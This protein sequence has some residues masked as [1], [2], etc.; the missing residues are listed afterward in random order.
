MKNNRIISSLVLVFAVIFTTTA[1]EYK[2]TASGKV[3]FNGINKISF[4]GHDGNE[5][6]ISTEN[7]SSSKSERA[8]G[9]K[10]IN[11][12]GLDDNTGIGLSVNKE[13]GMTQVDEISKR[14]SK[15]Y[16]VKV[17]NNVVIAYEHSTPHGSK[18]VFSDISSEVEVKTN[19]SSVKLDN[20][21][22]PMTISTVH[23][24]IEA[25][26]SSLNQDD[27]VSIASSHGLVDVS[28]PA[29]SKADVSMKSGWGEMYSDFDIN[30]EKSSSMKSY[31]SNEV[32]GTIN[33]GGVSLSLSSSH[34]NV[35]LRQSK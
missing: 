29:S 3:F 12:L 35:Y 34:G 31:S 24:K 5:I 9:L 21:T 6:I 18:V 10:L 8:E 7:R 19:H 30:I 28:L 2:F 26:F 4:E 17:P 25:T 27:P 13:E 22:G 1:Q 32:R 20:V 16:V 23:G 14:S 33:G 11:G 15:R